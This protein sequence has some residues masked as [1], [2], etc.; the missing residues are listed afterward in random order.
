MAA[1]ATDADKARIGRLF[2]GFVEQFVSLRDGTR[3]RVL[4][5]GDG[6]PV[7]LLHGWPQTLAAW[8]RVAPVLA[9][10]GFRVIV[11]DLPGYGA[12]CLA[13]RST[14]VHAP[15]RREFAFLVATLM[16]TLG[17]HRYAVVGHDRGARL[18]YRLGIDFPDRVT[19]FAS[20]TVVPTLEAWEAMDGA[21][22]LRAPHWF[23]FSLPPE[24]LERMI[25]ADPIGYLDHVLG[26]MAGNLD[27]LHPD[28]LD[29]YRSSISTRS[30]REAMFADYRCA[31]GV[32]LEHERND[33]D[34]GRK[35]Q[36]P[37]LCLWDAQKTR[38][39]PLDIWRNWAV[40]LTGS[41]LQGG[42][43]L[44]ELAANAVAGSLIPFLRRCRGGG[45]AATMQRSSPAG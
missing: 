1:V 12:S 4:S 43:L 6:D 13:P 11:P 37:V 21:F 19:G 36:C 15:S 31:L 42:H 18:G 33:R 5:G 9:A 20:L 23:F 44:P 14:A 38:G 3:F 2:P 28:A 16:Q 35:L 39:N 29:D 7:L 34:A 32:D 10:N 17:H 27:R 45:S 26:G 24:I 30:V 25:G 40:D 22:A 8:H 41:G